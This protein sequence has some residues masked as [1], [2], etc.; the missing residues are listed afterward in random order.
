[1]VGRRGAGKKKR[2]DA[3]CALAERSVSM[4]EIDTLVEL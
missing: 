3:P 2:M 1:M 4:R